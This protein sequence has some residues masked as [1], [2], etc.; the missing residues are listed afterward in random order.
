MSRAPSGVVWVSEA[1]RPQV[2]V[3]A[4][5]EEDLGPHAR[6]ALVRRQPVAR[7]GHRVGFLLAREREEIGRIEERRERLGVARRLREP[8]VEAA[9]ARARRVRKN[10]VERPPPLLVRVE[11]LIQEMAQQAPGLR[12]AVRDAVLH[13]GDARRVVLQIRDEVPDRGQ[14]SA[15]DDGALRAI[16]HLVDAAGCEPALQ[17]HGLR[18][19][20]DRAVLLLAGEAPRRAGDDR[21]VAGRQVARGQHVGGIVGVG[22]G[23]RHGP[24]RAH[25]VAQRDGVGRRLDRDVAAHEARDRVR[26]VA[27]CRRVEPQQVRRL[28]GQVELPAD[29]D[30]GEPALQ[31][32]RVAEI[33]WR[34][35]RQIPPRVQMEHEGRLVAAVRDVD[36]GHAASPLRVLRPEHHEVAP[37]LDLP[38]GVPGRQAQ[39]DDLPIVGIGRVEHVVDAADQALVR[40]GIAERAPVRHVLAGVDHDPDDAG[41]GRVGREREDNEGGECTG[42]RV[43]HAAGGTA[44]VHG[45]LQPDIIDRTAGFQRLR[46]NRGGP[47]ERTRRRKG[48][49]PPPAVHRLAAFGVRPRRAP[50]GSVRVGSSRGASR[51][52]PRRSGW[53]PSTH[54]VRSG[55]DP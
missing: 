12:D 47:P 44:G 11:P 31:Q 39:V 55:H 4:V 50:T 5:D 54:V 9:A 29:G 38:A 7:P 16:D 25:A 15:G 14:T 28:V 22:D 19:G 32:Q 37:R 24:R 27:C 20:D 43:E 35:R 40:T 8:V 49:P 17:V 45:D 3:A 48:R 53:S 46:R 34:V 33:L 10:G 51:P 1:P 41:V 6:G 26:G 42:E 18:I 52:P 13:R 23:V 36:Q 21:A 2:L 30:D